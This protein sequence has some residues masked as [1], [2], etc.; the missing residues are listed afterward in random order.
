MW[1]QHPVWMG[2][3]SLS[4]YL[5]SCVQATQ[6]VRFEWMNSVMVLCGCLCLCLDKKLCVFFFLKMTCLHVDFPQHTSVCKHPETIKWFAVLTRAV[7]VC[8]GEPRQPHLCPD[9]QWGHFCSSYESWLTQ[10]Q[11][12]PQYDPD[13]GHLGFEENAIH[14]SLCPLS[15]QLSFPGAFRN[16]LWP[17]PHLGELCSLSQT[18]LHLQLAGHDRKWTLDPSVCRQNLRWRDS[19]TAGTLVWLPIK[20]TRG[21]RGEKKV[22]FLPLIMSFTPDSLGFSLQGVGH[23]DGPPLTHPPG[24]VSADNPQMRRFLFFFSLFP[25]LL[26]LFIIFSQ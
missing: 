14:F 16:P 5:P 11:G 1:I 22:W 9:Q 24:P 17:A 8:G 10:P 7:L 13:P 2:Q 20:E 12:L 19:T 25:R 21:S 4:I 18:I 15:G 3:C 26:F 6:E 23:P